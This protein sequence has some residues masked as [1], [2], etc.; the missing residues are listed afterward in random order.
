MS[1]ELPARLGGAERLARSRAAITQAFDRDGDAH[2]YD[3]LGAEWGQAA[4]DPKATRPSGKSRSGWWPV[5]KSLTSSWWHR[6]PLNAMSHMARPVIETYAKR[7]PA[8]LLGAAALA[9]A[10]LVVV[11]PWRLISAGAL[12]AAVLRPSEISAFAMT[13]LSSFNG[14]LD[15]DRRQRA[16]AKAGAMRPG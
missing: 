4:A 7:E 9:G 3:D 8:K 5:A 12:L 14:T 10:V 1:R 15:L 16:A 6:H 13:M 11:R 2:D